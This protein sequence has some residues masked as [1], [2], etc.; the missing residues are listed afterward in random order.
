MASCPSGLSAEQHITCI[1][2]EGAGVNYQDHVA[3]RAAEIAAARAERLKS[4][5]ARGARDE[6]GTRAA[7]DSASTMN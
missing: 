5:S 7:N 4:E 2:V 1:N 3:E 6:T